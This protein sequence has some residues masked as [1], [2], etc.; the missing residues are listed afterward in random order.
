MLAGGIEFAGSFAVEPAV[1]SIQALPGGKVHFWDRFRGEV[2]VGGEWYPSP[3]IEEGAWPVLGQDHLE[4]RAFDPEAHRT[5]LLAIAHEIIELPDDGET[6]APALLEGILRR[7]PRDGKGFFSRAQIIAGLRYLCA[8]GLVDFD[9]ERLV[10]RMQMRPVR[11]QSGVTPLTILTRPH[12]CPGRCVFC[13]NDVRMPKSYLADEPGA[14][15]AAKN[16]FDPYLQTW[17]RLAAYKAIGHPTDKVEVII[18]GGTWS[19]HPESYQIYFI[20]RCFEALNDFG[21]GVDRRDQMAGPVRDFL[22]LTNPERKK[23]NE[24]VGSY[25]REEVGSSL[26]GE[27]EEA[28]WAELEQVQIENEQGGCRS[29]GLV[30]ETRPDH[31]SVEEV[32]RIRRLGC[33]KVQ[34]GFQSLSDEILE[35]NKRGHGVSETRAAVTLLRA[36]GF[37]LHAHWMP[38]LLGATPESDEL[39]FARIFDDPALRPDELKVYP[40]SLIETAELMDYYES[41]DWRPY[42]HDELLEVLVSALS[43]VPRYCRVTRVIRDISSDDIVTGNK[44]TNFRQIAENEV[45]ARGGKCEDIRSRE[46]RRES[47]SSDDMTLKKTEYDTTLGK[48]C[49]IEFVSPEDRIAGFARLC[50]PERKADLEELEASALLREVHVYGAATDLGMRPDQRAQH[51]GLGSR[52]VETAALHARDAGFGSLAVI[53]AIGTRGWYRRLGFED[54]LLYQHRTLR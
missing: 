43:S 18:L 17:N 5:D 26:L 6:I 11:T 42:E 40:C 49:F 50:L 48:E 30:I 1:Q 36:A 19:F 7:H 9:E 47:I 54:G 13:P 20:K 51:R 45:I 53:S 41:G 38:N 4:H 8:E 3:A 35:Q 44:L 12:P 15:R 31:I 34:I 2:P 25:L 52:L 28:S 24:T 32:M 21:Q 46:V 14:Q 29:V 10:R 23:Y 39:D 33:T 37:K 16:H 22:S 27:E